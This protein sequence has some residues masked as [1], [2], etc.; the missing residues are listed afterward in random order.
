MSMS[1]FKVWEL[2]MYEIRFTPQF[3]HFLASGRPG[4][5]VNES[6]SNSKT[7]HNAAIYSPCAY[8]AK[9]FQLLR[10]GSA[11]HVPCLSRTRQPSPAA[12]APS[13]TTSIP[14]IEPNPAQITRANSTWR[15]SNLGFPR[16]G[17]QPRRRS[18]FAAT[19]TT[20][21]PHW[22]LPLKT[23]LPMPTTPCRRYP[24]STKLQKPSSNQILRQRSQSLQQPFHTNCANQGRPAQPIFDEQDG[25]QRPKSTSSEHRPSRSSGERFGSL[26]SLRTLTLC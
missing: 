24:S 8:S 7:L 17:P 11:R 25:Q 23:T 3:H 20:K 4:S 21:T 22:S 26:L 16:F 12:F 9:L 15:V 1:A 6:I 2:C 14:I 13:P 10:P 19:M 5:E 18:A